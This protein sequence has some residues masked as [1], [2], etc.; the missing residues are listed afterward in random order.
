[1]TPLTYWTREY[2]W[3]RYGVR[4]IPHDSAFRPVEAADNAL[5]ELIREIRAAEDAL[6]RPHRYA[7]DGRRY[8]V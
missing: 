3:R 1:M 8:E 5:R 7:E 4:H 2:A 6:G